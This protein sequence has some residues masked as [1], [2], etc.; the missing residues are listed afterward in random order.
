MIKG[1]IFFHFN[2]NMMTQEQLETPVS[3][4]LFWYRPATASVGADIRGAIQG[5]DWT[6]DW[7]KFCPEDECVLAR[8]SSRAPTP[9][10]LQFVPNPATGNTTLVFN[11]LTNGKAQIVVMD[12]ISGRIL[13]TIST[14]VTRPGIQRIALA[15]DGLRDN[16]YAVQLSLN[17]QV[18]Y[19]ICAMIGV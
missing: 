15:L 14:T 17:S 16:V 11:T 1:N 12:K 9:T 6:L 5:T 7:A 18:W 2:R 19:A 3:T 13:H 4:S 8:S 10:T